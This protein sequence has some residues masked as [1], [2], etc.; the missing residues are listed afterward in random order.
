MMPQCGYKVMSSHKKLN[1]CANTTSTGLKFRRFDV[2]QEL[3]IVIVV[4]MLP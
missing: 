4:M 2:L 3:H 1:I